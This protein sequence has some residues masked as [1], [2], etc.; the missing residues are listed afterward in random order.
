[1]EEPVA[2]EEVMEEEPVAGEEVEEPV[3]GEELNTAD[4][5]IAELTDNSD[6][7]EI[8]AAAL[9]AADLPEILGS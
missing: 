8:L 1:M 4:F 7:F 5:T 6:S 2:D 9:A 3:A